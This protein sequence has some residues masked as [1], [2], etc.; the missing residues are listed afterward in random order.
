MSLHVRRAAAADAAAVAALSTQLGYASAE[1]QAAARLAALDGHPDIQALVA[2][3]D[4][5]VIGFVGL[6]VFPAFHRDG[7]H[8]Y[9]TALVVDASA[10]GS[11]AG[12]ALLQAAEAWFAERGVKRVNLTTA[13]HREA[14]HSFYEKRG[15]TFTG[16]RYSKIL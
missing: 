9:I 16:K 5:R 12:G 6:M 8:G 11:G 13:L 2:E 10:R 15:Y 14:A 1:P 3:Q 7:L 4:G